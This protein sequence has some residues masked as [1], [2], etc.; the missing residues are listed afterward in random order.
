MNLQDVAFLRDLA[1]E[2]DTAPRG[3]R[4]AIQMPPWPLRFAAVDDARATVAAARLLNLADATRM[5]YS[6]DFLESVLHRI[7]AR[8][9]LAIELLEICQADGTI[10]LDDPEIAEAVTEIRAIACQVGRLN[11]WP[12][13]KIR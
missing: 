4:S 13:S 8:A 11:L 1:N 2:L 6:T 3:T 10:C 5:E 7:G 9:R 12:S